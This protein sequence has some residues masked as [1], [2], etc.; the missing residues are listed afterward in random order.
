MSLEKITIQQ[1]DA[2]GVCSAPDVLSGTPA[3]NKAIFDRLVREL[4]AV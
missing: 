4:V 3:Q 2:M 1:M